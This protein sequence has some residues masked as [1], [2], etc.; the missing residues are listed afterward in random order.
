VALRE[1]FSTWPP[2][3]LDGALG[4]ELE[5]RGVRSDLPLWSTWAL[6]EVPEA[7]ES[8][9]REYLRA[10]AE[11]IT[12]NTF[13]TQR[14]TLARADVP[15]LEARAAALVELAVSLAR[16][17]IADASRPTW[18]AGSAPPLEDCYRP[19]LAPPSAEAWREHC[20][21]AA[22]L[23][24][25][26]VDV[27]AVETHNTIAEASLAARAAAQT[28]LPFWVSFVCAGGPRL[29]SG[30]PLSRALDAV[31]DAGPLAVGVNCLSPAEAT[32]CVPTLARSGLPFCVYA[33]ADRA[34][35]DRA[36]AEPA[37]ADPAADEYV[38]HAR[39]WLDAGARMIGGCCGTGPDHV[40]ALVNEITK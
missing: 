28:G 2:V 36:N 4:T 21:H 3:V 26:G 9:H 30:D 22:N 12:A 15:G 6:L 32:A 1:R 17:A 10:G 31:R 20:E 27:I 23:L 16:R 7:V 37:N 18:I 19:D 13:R 29:I 38:A 34:N 8:I 25:A 14:R 5:R 39:R 24:R 40:R 33:N 35:A 11:V